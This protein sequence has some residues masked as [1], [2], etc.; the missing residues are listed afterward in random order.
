MLDNF[1][2]LPI[3]FGLA[4]T[5]LR[6]NDFA[7]GRGWVES[8]LSRKIIH[9]GTGPLFVLCWLLFDDGPSARWLAALVPFAITIQFALVGT[10]M[11]KD[12]AAVQAMSRTG[13]RREI[14]RGPLLYGIVFVLVTLF[15]WKDHPAGLVALMLLCGG[16]GL[17]DIWGRKYGRRP[18]PWNRSK[19]L[20]G[21]LGMLL[22]GWLFALAVLAVYVAAGVFP[23]PIASY[24]L[25]VTLI[26]I[27][28]ALV[29]SL[30]LP[31]IDNL[32]ITATA[33]V[34]GAFIL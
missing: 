23:G 4:L 3:T 14:L 22:G 9:I 28:G 5:W 26:A 7:A 16:D 18:V 12:Q 17:A 11:I 24:L 8:G 2:A 33:L 19:T 31:E 27:A 10:G 32:T 1:L 21:S 13:D 29:E 30:P 25:P 34:L 15:Y 20:A 6:V